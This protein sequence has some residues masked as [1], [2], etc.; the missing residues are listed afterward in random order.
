MF[1]ASGPRVWEGIGGGYP[2]PPEEIGLEILGGLEGFKVIAST[3]LEASGLG[4]FRKHFFAVK[5]PR[6]DPRVDPG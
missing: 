6:V 1:A 2:P 4:R 5:S 3:R